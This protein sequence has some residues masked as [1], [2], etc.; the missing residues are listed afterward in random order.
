[1]RRYVN[2]V[3]GARVQVRDTKVMDSSWEEVRDEAPASGYAAMKVPE[4]K[5]E[6]ERRNTDRAEA[7]RIPGDGNKPDLVAALEADDAAAGQ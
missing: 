7:D 6:I 1:M 2:K 5:A 4:L 3:S